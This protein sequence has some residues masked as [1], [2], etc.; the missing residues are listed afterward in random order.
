MEWSEWL[1]NKRAAKQR[2]CQIA[3]HFLS[4]TPVPSLSD[5]P[6]PAR[7]RKKKG[8]GGE[9][10]GEEGKGG[11][12]EGKGGKGVE[13]G[14]VVERDWREE[15][16][17]NKLQELLQGR[18]DKNAKELFTFEEELESKFFFFFFMYIFIKVCLKCVYV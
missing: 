14:E 15:N 7:R 9:G 11:E 13:E 6:V 18:F 16:W 8:E 10:G 1:G 5:V 4:R 12:E 17:M 3:I 2:S